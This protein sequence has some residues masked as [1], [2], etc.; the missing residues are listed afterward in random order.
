MGLLEFAESS[1]AARRTIYMQMTAGF[2]QKLNRPGAWLLDTT[3]TMQSIMKGRIYV[4]EELQFAVLSNRRLTSLAEQTFLTDC[5]RS[6][7]NIGNQVESLAWACIEHSRCALL[8]AIAW[9]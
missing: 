6:L 2:L 1:S 7:N 4:S 5:K 8:L 3:H 9:H